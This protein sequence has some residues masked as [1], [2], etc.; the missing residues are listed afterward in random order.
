MDKLKLLKFKKFVN[1]FTCPF[2]AIYATIAVAIWQ[3]LSFGVL[4]PY[5]LPLW[6]Q[7]YLLM[8]LDEDTSD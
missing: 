5:I 6:E 8:E 7:A 2:R 3:V 4:S 1:S